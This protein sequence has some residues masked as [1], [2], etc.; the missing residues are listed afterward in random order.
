MNKR[1]AYVVNGYVGAKKCINAPSTDF[2]NFAAKTGAVLLTFGSLNRV[3]RV[4]FPRKLFQ[5]L[6]TVLLALK[7]ARNA[8]RYAAI[9]TSGED[10]GVF[11][12]IACRALRK[13]TRVVIIFHGPQ[14][15][16]WKFRVFFG[17]A[18][19]YP[20]V[21]LAC[22][23]ASLCDNL[24][25]LHGAAS[26]R[27]FD[28]GYGIDTEFF[29]SSGQPSQRIL[30]SAGTSNRDYNTLLL[31]ISDIG[32][33]TK[34]A[35]DSAWVK[36]DI[37]EGLV[38]IPPHAEIRSYGNYANL[39]ELYDQCRFVVVPTYPSPYAS[40]FA[41]IGEAMAMGKP[42]IVTTGPVQPD[43][44]VPGV[45]GLEVPAGNPGMLRAAILR[46]ME[47]DSLVERLG[48]NAEQTIRTHHSLDRYC[49]RLEQLARS[50]PLALHEQDV[51]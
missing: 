37:H 36:K 26:G 20:N 17:R 48:A 51:P 1:I 43:Y 28:A 9:I 24:I 11:V 41:V 49:H 32:V 47:D 16:S 18:V 25:R 45:T 12:A 29:K 4:D 22:L 39:R 13:R 3:F 10:I 19:R 31:A 6:R 30:A 21:V 46:L 2:D 40:G 5:R 35:A 23:S 50:S 8:H 15:Q 27:C 38:A 42:V 14:L 33:T 7:V 44:F 34:I